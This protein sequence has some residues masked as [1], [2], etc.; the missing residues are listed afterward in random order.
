MKKQKTIR[1]FISFVLYLAMTV[2]ALS[3]PALAEGANIEATSNG[4]ACGIC[5]GTAKWYG[6]PYTVTSTHYYLTTDSDGNTVSRLCTIEELRQDDRY[7]CTGCG[8]TLLVNDYII[9]VTHKNC[10]A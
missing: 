7:I 4:Y 3:V 1:M 2:S 6:G 5:G 10:G 8:T 9:S